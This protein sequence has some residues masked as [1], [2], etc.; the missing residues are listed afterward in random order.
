MD[1]RRGGVNPGGAC[2]N[3]F[4][5][6]A[7]SMIVADSWYANSKRILS[8]AKDSGITL[9]SRVAHNAVAHTVPKP[10]LGR[11]GRPKKYGNR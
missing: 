4:S 11:R 8:I 1:I 3:G 5:A 7:G 10:A 2:I 9:V 6:L